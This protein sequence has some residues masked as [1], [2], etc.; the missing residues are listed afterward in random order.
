MKT[1]DLHIRHLAILF[2]YLFIVWGFYRM[3]FQIPE[4]FDELLVKPVIWLVPVFLFL[5]KEKLGLKSIGI[6]SERLFPS[7]YFALILGSVFAFEGFAINYFKYNGSLF[8][9]DIGQ[10][11]LISAMALSV[12]T[13]ISEEVTFRGYF[14]SRLQ[15]ILKSEWK[16]ILVTSSGWT[17]IHLPVAILD[18]HM[19]ISSVLVYLA[20]VFIFG[21]GSAFIFARTKNVLSS[22]L[23][24]VLWAWPIMLFR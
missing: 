8:R 16:A 17:L 2:T 15:T 24:H 5:N 3:L 13:A 4:P 6:T 12:L 9:A 21:V 19:S 14:F 10:S 20:L 18:W 11:A 22:I 1:R 23:L 7:I